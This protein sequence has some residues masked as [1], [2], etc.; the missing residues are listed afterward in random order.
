MKHILNII[1]ISIASSI[2]CGCGTTATTT[3]TEY[4]SDGN[5]VKIT[6]TVSDVSDFSCLVA[7][8]EGNATT[9]S[10]DV[11]KFNLG[12]NGYGLNWL[13]VSG[14]RVKAPVKN[15]SNSAD[16]LEKTANIIQSKKTTLETGDFK[17]N[18]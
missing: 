4:N 10:A 7:S 8:S 1:L 3:V 18:N 14:I 12:W 11:T 6:E 15:G 5:V 2:V 17:V 13:S 9:L 16:A